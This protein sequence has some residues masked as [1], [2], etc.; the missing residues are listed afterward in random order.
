MFQLILN[1]FNISPNAIH[2][3]SSFIPAEVTNVT[4]VISE[5]YY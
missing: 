5:L 4:I 2:I 1:N 3:F